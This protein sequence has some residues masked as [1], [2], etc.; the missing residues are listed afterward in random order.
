MSFASNVVDLRCFANEQPNVVIDS[1]NSSARSTSISSTS[2]SNLSD[3]SIWLTNLPILLLL[4]I[5]LQGILELELGRV[6][7]IIL[8]SGFHELNFKS[9]TIVYSTHA[10]VSVCYFS[11]WGTILLDNLCDRLVNC[12]NVLSS[13]TERANLIIVPNRHLSIAKGVLRVFYDD[14]YCVCTIHLLSNLKL[15]FKDP[16]HDKYFF[17]CAFVY[18]VN[19]IE[20]HMMCMESVSPNIKDYLISIGFKKSS[21]AYSRK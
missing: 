7:P 20:E 11:D 9:F 8:A 5:L 18:T 3:G 15:H 16:L 19:E 4:R 21:R 1:T 10:Y 6:G 14:E 13:I 12:I 17:S 2:G